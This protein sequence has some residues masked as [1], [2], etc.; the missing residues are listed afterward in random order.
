L[1]RLPERL[2]KEARSSELSARRAA[3]QVQ[4][5]VAIEILLMAPIRIENLSELDLDRH[6]VRPGRSSDALHIVFVE[7]E[8]KNNADL[9]FPLPKESA[10]LIEHYVSDYRPLLAGHAN[11]MLFPGKSKPAKSIGMQR[12]QL[13]KTIFRYT[14]LKMHP[15]LFRHAGAK[16]FLDHNPGAYEVVR[17]VLAHASI[18]TTTDFHTGSETAS[19]VRHFD[20]VILGLRHSTPRGRP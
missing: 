9:H 17:R 7:D 3:L 4:T 10:A 14:G 16:V 19:A 11:R 8:V 1:V 2:M 18:K 12:Q 20:D 13:S 15:H 5:A 6:L